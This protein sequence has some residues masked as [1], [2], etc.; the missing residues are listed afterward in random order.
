MNYVIHPS[1]EVN[2]FTQKSVYHAYFENE[3]KRVSGYKL[4]KNH[5]K[6][7]VHIVNTLPPIEGD[8][9][10]LR[11]MVFKKYFKC[12]YLIRDLPTNNVD[13]YFKDSFRGRIYPKSITLILQAQILEPVIYYKFLERNILFM[14]AAGLSDGK[15]GYL[16]PAHGGT[17]KTTLTLGLMGEGMDVLGDDLLL[18]EPDTKTVYPYLRPLH[19]FTYN[20]NTLRNA[21]LPLGV[22]L[23]LVAKDLIRWLLGAFTRQEFLISTRVHADELYKNFQAGKKVTYRKIIFLRKTGNHERIGI[24]RKNIETLAKEIL[25]SADLNKS[26]Y[27]NILID[28]EQWVVEEREVEVACNVILQADSFEY[29]NTRLLNFRDLSAFKKS[30]ITS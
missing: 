29:V 10:R 13:I 23:K 12:E 22:K 28:A 11:L 25:K 27:E 20:A 19:I 1:L 18:V 5:T 9:D 21:D 4:S 2:I 26:L 7:N 30:L 17:G 15:S 3:Y 16:F 6:I 14:H 8:N 24:T